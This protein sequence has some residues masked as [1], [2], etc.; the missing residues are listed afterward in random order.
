MAGP[1]TL[2]QGG[3]ALIAR[4]P[5]FTPPEQHFWGLLSVVLDIEKIYNNSGIYELEKN[6][7]VAIVT[8]P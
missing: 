3:E 7:D 5:V 8:R 1:L 4:V 6:Y 2:V